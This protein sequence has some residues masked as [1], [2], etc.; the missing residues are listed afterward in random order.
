MPDRFT[1]PTPLAG[2][3]VID[4]TSQLDTVLSMLACHV[5]QVFEWLPFN[6]G[7]E[8]QVPDD[9][10]GRRAWLRGWYLP[11]LRPAADRYREE[12]I[13]AYGSVRGRQTEYAEA[14]EIS[15]HAAP[16]NADTRERLFGAIVIGR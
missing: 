5:S 11:Y 15:E 16:L 8:E 6:Q 13:S 12:L 7:I 1:K 10:D 2:D 3:V 14:Y 9:M 4:V